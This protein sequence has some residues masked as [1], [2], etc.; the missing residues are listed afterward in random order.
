M[1]DEYIELIKKIADSYD[2]NITI[3]KRKSEE[4]DSEIIL[5]SQNE[6]TKDE[7][8]TECLLTNK[9]LK[10]DGLIN[11]NDHK[12]IICMH[13]KYNKYYCLHNILII[14]RIEFLKFLIN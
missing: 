1:L 10:T 9:K 4:N 11:E 8:D 2:K 3:I 14:T 12:K 7:N 13:A 6:L 5:N